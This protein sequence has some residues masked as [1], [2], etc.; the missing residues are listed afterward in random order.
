MRNKII[1]YLKSNEGKKIFQ[2]IIEKIG[3]TNI[4]IDSQL[5][6]FHTK[7]G[8]KENFVFIIEKIIQKYESSK[9]RDMWYKRNIEPPE[10]LYWFLYD[11]AN[12]YGRKC[13]ENEW[14]EY[15]NVFSS[16]LVYLNGYYFNI[17]NGQGVAI[18]IKKENK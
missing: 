4:I 6:R 1:E 10:S 5:E 7:F 8:N 17:M 11:Y 13:N 15:G 9:Y 2:E 3:N 18:E 12:K 16:D 14:E